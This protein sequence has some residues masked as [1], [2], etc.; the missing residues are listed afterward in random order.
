[1]KQDDNGLQIARLLVQKHGE[2]APIRASVQA[3]RR[4]AA[5]DF[6]GGATWIGIVRAV[7]EI[8]GN[9][10]GDPAR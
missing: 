2:D 4:L 8:L 6:K 5:E 9:I 7:D 10:E 1:M 3:Q